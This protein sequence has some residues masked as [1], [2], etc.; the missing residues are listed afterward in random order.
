MPA[1]TPQILWAQMVDQTKFATLRRAQ[2]VWAVAAIHGDVHRLSHIHAQLEPRFEPGDR[3]VYMG[4]YLGHHASHILATVDELLAFR[5]NILAR[6]RARACDVVF[7]RGSQEEMW[8]KLMQLHLALDP[9]NV[10]NWMFARGVA[11]TLA[12]YGFS[13]PDGLVQARSGAGQ[14][15]RWTSAVRRAVRAQPGH[16]AFMGC[17]RRAAF[18]DDGALLFVHA[19]VDTSRPLFTQSDTLW[20][21]GTQF[22]QITEP[23]EGVKKIV[24]GLAPDGYGVKLTPLTAS[25]DGG[26]GFGGPLYAACFDTSGAMV[27]RVEG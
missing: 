27:D 1:I 22:S 18:T 15:A 23:Y 8:H 20:W 4:N 21:G 19:G 25:L 12:A 24:R 11:E 9:V 3:L 10:L 26:C 6:P 2:R 5:R 7:L 17:L 14:T 13:A 16:D